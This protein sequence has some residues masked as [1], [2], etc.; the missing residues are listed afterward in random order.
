MT[1]I[2]LYQIDLDLFAHVRSQKYN[3]D[4]WTASIDVALVFSVFTI[5]ARN[6]AGQN[7]FK[8]ISADNKNMCEACSN[9]AIMTPSQ[10][11]NINIPILDNINQFTNL[12]DSAYVSLAFAL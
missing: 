5:K 7:L 12:N 1:V 3:K 9:L 6:A 4:T 10:K 8:I 2:S 11:F